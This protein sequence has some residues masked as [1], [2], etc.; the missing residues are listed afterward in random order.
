M[1]VGYR[2]DFLH[3]SCA[4]G[5][6]NDGPW[7]ATVGSTTFLCTVPEDDW[8]WH[9]ICFGTACYTGSDSDGISVRCVQDYPEE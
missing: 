1:P 2:L 9:S 8:Q 4:D 5:E 3:S 7:C 6:F